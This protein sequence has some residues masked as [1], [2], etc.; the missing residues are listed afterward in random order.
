M[1]RSTAPISSHNTGLA[2]GQY[3]QTLFSRRMYNQRIFSRRGGVRAGH[4][5]SYLLTAVVNGISHSLLFDGGPRPELWRINADKLQLE[6][7]SIDAVV[8]SHWWVQRPIP[9]RPACTAS[10]GST[11]PTLHGLDVCVAGRARACALHGSV[12]CSAAESAHTATTTQLLYATLRFGGEGEGE[13][14]RRARGA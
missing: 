14:E 1:Q 3:N 8:L 5:T 2:Q 6:A 11:V 12:A 13:G 10:G 4:G 7:G 9:H